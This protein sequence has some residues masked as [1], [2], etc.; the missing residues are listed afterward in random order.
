MS[1]CRTLTHLALHHHMSFSQ[2]LSALACQAVHQLLTAGRQQQLKA[3]GK[4]AGAR[5]LECQRVTAA[6]E[7]AQHRT[8]RLT[9]SI[10]MFRDQSHALYHN[11][12]PG[13]FR[14]MCILGLCARQLLCKGRLT[15][16]PSL[17]PL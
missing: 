11:L 16:H 8:A 17:Q 2:G 12:L 1:A 5:R 7:S 9:H 4:A 13:L 10:T 14:G 3:A 15:S 6:V